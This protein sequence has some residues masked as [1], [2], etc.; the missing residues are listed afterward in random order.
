MVGECEPPWRWNQSPI[1]TPE[2]RSR[3]TRKAA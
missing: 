1:A 3:E 2:R